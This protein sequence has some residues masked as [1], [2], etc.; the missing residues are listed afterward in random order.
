MSM[1]IAAG[2]LMVVPG[3]TTMCRYVD[4]L[5]E[6][7]V[8]FELPFTVFVIASAVFAIIG[9]LF[10]LRR[11]YWAL[12]FTSSLFFNYFVLLMCASRIFPYVLTWFLAP[13]GIVPLMF[14]C[15]RRG[16]WQGTLA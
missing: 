13:A 14:T 15:L 5:G 7:D 6:N 9:G 11:K 2:I 10:C 1:R 12:C 4:V 3:L 16:E 8:Y